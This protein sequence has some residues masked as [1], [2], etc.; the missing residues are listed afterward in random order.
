VSRRGVRASG[1]NSAAPRVVGE[2]AI[3]SDAYDSR[4]AK[5]WVWRR[6]VFTVPEGPWPCRTCSEYLTP[7]TKARREIVGGEA[8]YRHFD[9]IQP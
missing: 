7:G 6:R 2:R 4:Y 3:E 8:F 1:W 5:T 9:C